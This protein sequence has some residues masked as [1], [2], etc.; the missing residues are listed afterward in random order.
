MNYRDPLLL[1]LEALRDSLPSVLSLLIKTGEEEEEEEEALA[2]AL[3]RFVNSFLAASSSTACYSWALT[4]TFSAEC[5][6][7]IGS[8][9]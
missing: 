8:R 7:R 3:A 6:V 4:G 1:L 9:V 5:G 2:E